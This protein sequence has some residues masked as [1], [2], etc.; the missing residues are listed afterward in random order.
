MKGACFNEYKGYVKIAKRRV[1]PSC[2][3]E[4]LSIDKKSMLLTLTIFLARVRHVNS[5]KFIHPECVIDRND[6]QLCTT[7][8]AK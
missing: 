6:Y 3:L 7:V 5:R 4:I 8:E 1:C 2:Y